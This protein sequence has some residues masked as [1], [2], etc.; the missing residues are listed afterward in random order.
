MIKQLICGEL[1]RFIHE[2]RFKQNILLLFLS[3]LCCFCFLFFYEE[4]KEEIV[5]ASLMN[6]NGVT[7]DIKS[8]NLGLIK[9]W[10]SNVNALLSTESVFDSI[11]P[12]GCIA[13]LVG[14]FSASYSN[15]YRNHTS[16]YLVTRQMSIKHIVSTFIVSEVVMT[17]VWVFIYEVS[18]FIL[19]VFGCIFSSMS[20]SFPREFVLWIFNIHINC[21]AFSLFISAI[22]VIVRKL[23]GVIIM[24]ISLV[25]A[26]AKC[27]EL[28][29]LFFGLPNDVRKVWVLNN[30]I[31]TSIRSV[32][33]NSIVEMFMIAFITSVVAIGIILLEFTINKR[34]RYR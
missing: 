28:I 6:I 25:F 7:S 15:L 11:M 2:K 13:M 9:I 31:N 33:M 4:V 16:V 22:F 14:M 5:G 12:S 30:L 3:A 17:N 26:G 23:I 19:C 20:F 8:Y 34:E 24:C 29:I 18:V 32:D 10:N 1:F 27:L 21:T